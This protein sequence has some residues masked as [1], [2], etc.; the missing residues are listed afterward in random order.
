MG[1]FLAF[2]RA[3][4]CMCPAAGTQARGR[5]SHCA[6]TDVLALCFQGSFTGGAPGKYVLPFSDVPMPRGHLYL[7]GCCRSVCFPQALHGHRAGIALPPPCCCRRAADGNTALLSNISATF[8]ALSCRKQTLQQDG[9][10]AALTRSPRRCRCGA[11]LR[12]QSKAGPEQRRR[13]K[14]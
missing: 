12:C 11:P 8:T 1:R 14:R 4:S 3:A 10:V 6:D 7:H 2:Q 13:E 9:V 5:A